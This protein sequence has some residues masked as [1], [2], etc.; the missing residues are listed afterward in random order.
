[1]RYVEVRKRLSIPMG[2][3]VN[4]IRVM[5][6]PLAGGAIDTYLARVVRDRPETP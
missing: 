6:K 2:A 4:N 3:R 1:M 5:V